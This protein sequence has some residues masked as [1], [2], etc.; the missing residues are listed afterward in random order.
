MTAPDRTIHLAL[1]QD[2]FIGSRI[3]HSVIRGEN[4][5]VRHP[6]GGNCDDVSLPKPGVYL[7]SKYEEVNS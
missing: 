2:L 6:G 7:V 3:A 5:S 4:D 1:P